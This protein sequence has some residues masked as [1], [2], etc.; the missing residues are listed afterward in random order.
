[1]KIM[2]WSFLLTIY[3]IFVIKVI[4][5][6]GN[7][8]DKNAAEIYNFVGSNDNIEKFYSCVTRLRI[9]VKDKSLINEEQIKN[10]KLVKGINWND[11]ELQIIIGN[12]V[13]AVYDSFDKTVNAQNKLAKK[14]KTAKNADFEVDKGKKNKSFGKRFIT[15]L[16]SILV[17]A[18][19]IFIVTG[20]LMGFKSIMVVAGVMK[21]PS[22]LGSVK[23]LPTFDA[24]FWGISEIGTRFLALFIGYNTM[25]YLKGNLM[26]SLFLSLAIANPLLY[27]MKWHLFNLGSLEIVVQP[28]ASSI[29]PM[30]AANILYFYLDKGLK[31]VLS[32]KLDLFL[33]PL[34]AYTVTVLATY[35][36][37]GPV[38]YTI[39]QL[40]GKGIYKLAEIPYGF[41]VMILAMF[42]S[43]LVVT[44]T[45]LTAIIILVREIHVTGSSALMPATLLADYAQLGAMIGVL[46]RTKNAKTKEYCWATMV[47]G[48]LGV[49][50]PAVYGINLPKWRPWLCGCLGA[51][52][53][54][55]FSGLFK[56]REVSQ[57]AFGIFNLISYV[58]DNPWNLIF[59]IFA[60]LIALGTSILFTSLIYNEHPSEIKAIK[61][62]NRQVIH[63]YAKLEKNKALVDMVDKSLKKA[64]TFDKVTLETIKRLEKSYIKINQLDFDIN[65]LEAKKHI[66]LNKLALLKTE[67][68]ECKKKIETDEIYLRTVQK[69]MMQNVDLILKKMDFTTNSWEFNVFES[70][71]F[72]AIYSLNI[73][74]DLEK[75]KDNS[76]TFKN[77][78]KLKKVGMLAYS[79]N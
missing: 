79:T 8:Y 67:L 39:E 38:L 73:S 24:V 16:N 29:L 53:G 72:N 55:L 14:T 19:P 4:M 78:R 35:F 10:I 66:D 49:S 57:P 31:K 30:I 68:L 54:G 60:L 34:V 45:H 13:T 25:K 18:I 22:P 12:E 7:I 69:Q 27:G 58:S 46:I 61:K 48:F 62:I 37:I 41:G 70:N 50:E 76:Y 28:Y 9:R 26:M 23:D 52:C 15:A 3:F 47:P 2:S 64:T 51:A 5:K 11:N 56:V 44:G 32:P 42:W 6:K 75:K 1:M 21:A 17:P 71:Y 20:F 74:Y 43:P 63:K 59:Y 36:F 40:A 33:R 65:G 77:I